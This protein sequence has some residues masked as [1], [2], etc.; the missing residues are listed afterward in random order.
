MNR[1]PPWLYSALIFGVAGALGTTSCL[2]NAVFTTNFSS[3]PPGTSVLS[4]AVVDGGILKLTNAVNAQNGF[5]YINDL[6]PGFAVDS[7]TATFKAFVGGGTCCGGLSTADGFSFNFANDLPVLGFQGEE[8]GGT[9]LTVSFDSFDNGPPDAAPAIDVKLGG[10]A[11]GRVLTQVSQGLNAPLNFWD[12]FIKLDSDGT[13]DVS[14]NNAPIYTN[15]ST[16]Y[17][18]I[19]GGQFAFGARTG[20]ANDN[21]WIDDLT[22]ETQTSAAVPEPAT[23]ALLGLG[24]AGLGFSRRK[25]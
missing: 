19:A 5:F 13:L 4:D 16:G 18:P 9:G 2:A 7:F 17:T 24:L 10:V 21:H 20:G 23:L 1:S 6:E 14:Y 11:I 15:F 12:V 25:Q 22:I 3:L 8:G